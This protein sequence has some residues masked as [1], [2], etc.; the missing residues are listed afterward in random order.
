MLYRN[1]LHW[2]PMISLLTDISLCPLPWFFP[3]QCP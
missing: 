3:L 2:H 1:F